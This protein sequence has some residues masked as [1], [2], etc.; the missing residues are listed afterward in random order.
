M[1]SAPPAP[2]EGRP[3]GS[4]VP[5]MW[6]FVEMRDYAVPTLPVS[7]AAAAAW[8]SLRRLL[9]R[10]MEGHE[11]AAKREAEL[12]RMSELRLEHLVAPIDWAA[13]SVELDAAVSEQFSGR[14]PGSSN[15]V[16][17]LIGQPHCGHAEIVEA[18]AARQGA[19]IVTAPAPDELLRRAVPTLQWPEGGRPWALPRLERH[20][21]RHADGLSHVRALLQDAASGRAGP[22]LVG[23]DS[24]AWAYLRRIWP[25]ALPK[26]LTLQAFD[27]PRL[28][29]LLTRLAAPAG[30]RRLQFRNA[31]TGSQML[32]VPMDDAA[33]P[34]EEVERLAAHCRGNVGVARRYWRELLRTEP[35]DD[36]AAANADSESESDGDGSSESERPGRVVWVAAQLED[37]DLPAESDE[38]LGLVLHAI[39]LHGGLP[40]ALL[41][42]VLPMAAA[43]CSA[44][45]LRLAALGLVERSADDRW[46][47]A[48]LS[49]T[50]VR[51]W[52][53]GQ[54][55]LTDDF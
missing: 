24:W 19:E 22:G 11:V 28:A 33:I 8:N 40:E 43:R 6:S 26:T 5:P 55:Y 13:A 17:F 38:D 12:R 20:F 27:A 14:G 41:P 51:R 16:I 50:M 18:W 52:L 10:K 34:G 4:D 54:G 15:G 35:D 9:A 48:P 45:L 49:Y 25:L 31:R 30:K 47:V 21:L 32:T 44:Q 36:E 7:G 42:E 37:S 53:R 39:L 23:C 29:R 46:A 3:D 1:S 2:M